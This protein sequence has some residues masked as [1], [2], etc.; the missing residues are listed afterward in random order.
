MNP[1]NIFTRLWDDYI[2][3]NPAAKKVYDVLTASGEEVVN[4]HIAFRTFDHPAINVERLAQ[5]FLKAGYVEKG[6]YR[7]EEKKLWA[8]HY[9]LPGDEKAPRVFISELLTREFSP[10]LQTTIGETIRKMPADLATSDEL[11]FSGNVFGLPSF[12]V[13][14]KLREE[15]EYAA[16]VYVYGFRANHFTVYVNFLKKYN[17]LQK[18]NAFLKENGFRIND[19]GGEIKGTPAELLEQ[20]SIR[21]GIIPVQFVEGIFDIPSCY[22]EFALRYPGKNGRLYSGFIAKSADKIF[23]STDFYKDSAKKQ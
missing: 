5:V 3:Q 7:F 10:F 9:E 18:L 11:I 13:Y 14:N 2:T 16:W 8:K 15:S 23:E 12:D 19:S 4:D 22:Y 21:A 20:S 6:Q 1:T 17:T